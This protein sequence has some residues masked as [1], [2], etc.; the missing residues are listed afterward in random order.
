MRREWAIAEKS[1]ACK[2]RER[3]EKKKSGP[4]AALA[5]EETQG[6]KRRAIIFRMRQGEVVRLLGREGK[7]GKSPEGLTASSIRPSCTRARQGD[8]T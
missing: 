7:E 4:T 1:W 3:R 6:K 5:V 8:T 2:G